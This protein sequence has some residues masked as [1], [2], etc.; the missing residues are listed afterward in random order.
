MILTVQLWDKIFTLVW[1]YLCLEIWP[2]LNLKFN[3]LSEMLHI[4]C[5]WQFYSFDDKKY[6]SGK[7]VVFS[8]S[9]NYFCF[10]FQI[11]CCFKLYFL[12]TYKPNF[13]GTYPWINLMPFIFINSIGHW[14]LFAK[15][16]GS[17]VWWKRLMIVGKKYGWFQLDQNHVGEKVMQS[18]IFK[19]WGSC[20]QWQVTETFSDM[21]CLRRPA[22]SSEIV[23][24]ANDSMT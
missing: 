2:F 24:V 22:K 17:S 5:C 21:P 7:K 4:I 16:K 15:W 10:F 20:R 1:I 18:M 11:K 8:F 23:V 6:Y 12:D 3:Y 9:I 13:I 14:I 19:H